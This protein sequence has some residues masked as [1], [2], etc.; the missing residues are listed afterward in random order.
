[1]HNASANRGACIQNCRHQYIVTDKED[2][3]ELEIDNEYIMSAKDLC[4]IE[5]LDKIIHAGVKVLKIEG[6]GRSV[7]Y[8]YTVTQ[9]YK[10]ALSAI[11]EGT[12]TTEKIKAWN[13]RLATVYNRGFWEGYYL[14]RKIG[15]WSNEYGS[16][17]TKKKIY[18]AKGKKYFEKKNIGEFLIESNEGLFIGDQIIIIGPTTGLISMHINELWVENKPVQKAKKGDTITMPIKNKIRASDKIY[19]IV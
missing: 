13:K 8:V 3:H 19:K 1:T 6:R 7:D 11:E 12:Y 4:T 2:N 17:A 14:G 5:F 9:C 10:E 18:I 15:E 16:K